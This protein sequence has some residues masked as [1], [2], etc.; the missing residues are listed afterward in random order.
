MRSPIWMA[1]RL[2]AGLLWIAMLNMPVN[3][4]KTAIAAEQL[5][6][7]AED[8]FVL[9]LPSISSGCVCYYVDSVG[10]SDSNAGTSESQPWRTLAKVNATNFQ[11][12]N[13]VKFKRG[14]SWTGTLVI[15]DS[16]TAGNPIRFAAYGSGPRP[17]L[18]NP[19]APGS[20]TRAI[21]IYADWIVIEGFLIR[22][23][24]EIGIQV[25]IGSDRNVIQD[26]EITEAGI[27]VEISGQYNLFTQNYVH[28][29]H[30]VKN[31]PGGTDDYGAIGATLNRGAFN[32]VSYN[33]FVNCRSP[34]YD[35]GFDGGAIEWFG[36]NADNNF[37]HHNWATGNSGFLEVGG[38]SAKDTVVAYNV[39]FNNSRF[40]YMNLANQYQSTITNFRIENNSII[41]IATGTRLW[42]IFG[43]DTTPQATTMVARNNI[44]YADNFSYVA[45]TAGF[46]HSHNLFFLGNGT[47]LGF[48]L[49]T[50]EAV[51]NPLFVDIATQNFRLQSESPA[52][53]KGLDL[54]YL[55]DYEGR[56]VPVGSAPDL[57]SF[58]AELP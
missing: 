43:F 20:A 12:G 16:G 6:A 57:G 21:T 38:G 13:I 47:A 35:Y 51:A 45:H 8:T 49:A 11:P 31:T 48:N 19:G 10:G 15:N 56:A 54:G 26:N 37:V 25:W 41:E 32:E 28:D 22:D 40:S 23:V 17:V 7:T 58:E 46:A 30:M 33:R 34:S 1:C 18:T 2:G 27:G 14:G 4:A 29:L 5:S 55:V 3:L 53:D 24:P 39:S 36:A 9:Y 50:G 52:I 42:T 44:I